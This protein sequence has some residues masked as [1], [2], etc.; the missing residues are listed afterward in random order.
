[1]HLI[2]PSYFK[3]QVRWLPSLT[4]VTYLSKL[5]GIHSV[6]AFLQLELF[7][8]YMAKIMYQAKNRYI[9][10]PSDDKDKIPKKRNHVLIKRKLRFI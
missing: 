1:M 9:S 6:A 7:W 3:L 4:P 10:L 2:Y 8:V 5:L